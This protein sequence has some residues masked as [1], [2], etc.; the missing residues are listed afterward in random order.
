MAALA[1]IPLLAL[2]TIAGLSLFRLQRPTADSAPAV[3]SSAPSSQRYAA[4]PSAEVDAAHQAL[5]DLGDACAEEPSPSLP[6]VSQATDALLRFATRHPDGRFPIDDETGT[7]LSLLLVVRDE[8]STCAPE[9]RPRVEALLPPQLRATV[10][11]QA[12]NS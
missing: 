6:D 11:G 4:V 3:L 9:L 12:T 5:H 7:T 8:L 10:T 1:A 2:L